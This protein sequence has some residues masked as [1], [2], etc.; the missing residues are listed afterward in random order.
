M[1]NVALTGNVAAGKSTVVAL[2]REWGATVIDADR[3]VREIQ[4]AGS[5]GLAEIAERLGPHLVRADGELDR[6]ALRALVLKDPAAMKALEG[7]VHPRVHTRR[8]ELLAEAHARGDRVVINDIPLL[9]EAA[10]PD[11]FDAVVLVDA[12]VHERRRRLVE[13]RGLDPAEADRLIAAQMPSERKRDASTFVIDN[14][15]DRAELER[16]AR[17][18]WRGLLRLADGARARD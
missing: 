17:A 13:L 15:G 2:F 18:V 8:D 9:F 3:I 12:P 10:D 1:L 11:A 4:A 14:A 5:P 7:I 16:Q 6:P